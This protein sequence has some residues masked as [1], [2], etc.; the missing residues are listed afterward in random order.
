MRMGTCEECDR[1]FEH[2]GTRGPVPSLCPDHKREQLAIKSRLNRAKDKSPAPV[3]AVTSG[4]VAAPR[5]VIAPEF[6]GVAL[7]ATFAELMNAVVWLERAMDG[8]RPITDQPAPPEIVQHWL[9]TDNLL[10]VVRRL[11]RATLA[12]AQQHSPN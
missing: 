2:S 11:T 6:S 5:G 7:P 1:R 10:S 4:M 9:A 3:L 8:V 12:D